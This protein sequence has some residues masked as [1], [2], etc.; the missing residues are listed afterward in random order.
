MN[1]RQF[2][3]TISFT[4]MGT[5]LLPASR[6][7]PHAEHS[8]KTHQARRTRDFIDSMGVA[9]H[10][11]YPDTPYGFDYTNVRDKLVESGITHVRDG[12]SNRIQDLGNRG[13]KSMIVAD[14]PNN[15]HGDIED[16][17][18]IRDRI[19]QENRNDLFIDA[20]EGPNE[21][22]IFWERFKK[23]YNGD[24]YQQGQAGI[25]KGAVQFQKDVYTTLKSDPETEPLT[26]MGM[27][28]GRTYDPGAGYPNPLEDGE[29][30]EFVDWGNFHPYPGG[31]N[32]F[33]Y[34][35]SYAGI[36]KYYW[37]SNFPSINL[38]EYPYAFDTYH[39]PYAPKPMASSE[40]GW[41]SHAKGIS[42]RTHGKYIPRLYAEYFRLGIQRAFIYEFIDEFKDPDKSNPEANYGLLR[43][44]TS[45]KPGYTAIKNLIELLKDEGP[46]FEPGVLNYRFCRFSKG[47]YNKTYFVH[48]L[49]LQKSDG[50]FYILLWHEISAEDISVH[51]HKQLQHP[52][53]PVELEFNE[54][55]S[56]VTVYR[57][58]QKMSFEEQTAEL[59]NDT[60]SL[61]VPDRIMVV[62][63]KPGV[64]RIEHERSIKSF[65]LFQNYP[66]PFNPVTTIAY[67]LPH[68]SHVRLQVHNL[69][70][71]V[72]TTLVDERQEAGLHKIAFS[73]SRLPSGTYWYR[74]T[75]SHFSQVRKMVLIR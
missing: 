53:M 15:A 17:R 29:L 63:V 64:S 28:L 10:W 1:R 24:G 67:Q 3:R 55:I 26:V 30:T 56:K 18:N 12:F 16:V 49:L 68:K 66:N 21:V 72:L 2:L 54:P 47:D 75:A 11:N 25:I 38:D 59:D 73:N 35:Y 37:Q 36:E 40:T 41:A 60:L 51:P 45:P 50:D 33:S 5:V 57:Y 69:S 8:A 7:F 20:V 48:Q 4:S 42:E 44:D 58:N 70:G 6:L 65:H 23:T 61:S 34:P 74:L 9:V 27:A 62:R 46:E 32:P 19:K 39:P 31:G 14:L 43:R 13:I 71:R 52:D 22:D